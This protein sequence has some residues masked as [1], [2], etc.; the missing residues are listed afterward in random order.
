MDAN[1]A[2]R[3]F[4]ALAQDSRLEAFRLLVRAGEVGLPAGE[5]ARTL[6]IPHNTL[7]SHLSILAQA[8]LVTSRRDGRLI[9]YRIDFEGT[10]TLLA[11][12]MEDC[13]QGRPDL[14]A[15]LL[16]CVQPVG[17]GPTTSDKGVAS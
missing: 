1:I 15:P 5:I 7:S 11:F 16:A 9:I 10:R 2:I 6:A 3:A 13:C 12:L 17:C 4:G 8:G 14:C